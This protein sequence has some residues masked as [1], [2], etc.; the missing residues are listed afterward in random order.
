MSPK[1]WDFEA[2]F[3]STCQQESLQP[4]PQR[5]SIDAS[6][7]DSLSLALEEMIESGTFDAFIQETGLFDS[8]QEAFIDP[9]VMEDVS[10]CESEPE[11]IFAAPAPVQSFVRQRRHSIG[12]PGSG[13]LK[14]CPFPGCNKV[15]ER[16]YNLQSHL[17]VHVQDKPHK[18]TECE[19]SFSRGHD[20]KRHMNTHTRSHLISC[21]HC[22]RHFSRQDALHRHLRLGACQQ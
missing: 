2:S 22:R 10:D 9:Q 4:R 16:S 3:V 11:A 5:H 19:A 17:K 18:C 1:P 14:K 21:P 15:F 13:E 7:N 8:L 6:G 12:T 20:L